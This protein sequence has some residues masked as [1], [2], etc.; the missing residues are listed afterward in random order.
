MNPTQLASGPKFIRIGF[1]GGAGVGGAGAYD[2]VAALRNP[3]E[4]YSYISGL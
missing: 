3:A 4:K 1:G 2:S